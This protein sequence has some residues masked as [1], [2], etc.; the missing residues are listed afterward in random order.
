MV[1]IIIPVLNEEKTIIQTL[2]NVSR[3]VGE[4]EIIVVDGGSTD[5]TVELARTY[6]RVIQSEKGRAKQMN[7]GAKVA[8]R[9]YSLV[10]SFRL[11]A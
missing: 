2:Q 8:K 11:G 10:Y 7:A 6:A 9:Q 4:K 1:T 3:L 5:K